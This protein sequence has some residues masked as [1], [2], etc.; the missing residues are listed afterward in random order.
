[1]IPEDQ[2]Y[3]RHPHTPCVLYVAGWRTWREDAPSGGARGHL[4]HRLPGY[5]DHGPPAVSPSAQA[6]PPDVHPHV[7]LWRYRWL[8]TAITCLRVVNVTGMLVRMCLHDLGFILKYKV[9]LNSEILN[10]L[11]KT[12]TQKLYF[13]NCLL[14]WDVVCN[15]KQTK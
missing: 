12:N 3:K 9:H 13:E 14:Y 11:H 10:Y 1:M 2:Q 15:K 8:Q 5:P 6:P 7:R 4:R